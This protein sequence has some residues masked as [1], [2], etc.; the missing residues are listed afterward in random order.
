MCAGL[1]ISSFHGHF[2]IRS[3]DLLALPTVDEDKSFAIQISHE[4][5]LVTQQT[6]Y[7]QCALL[8]T[9]SSGE[10]RI[11]VHTVAAPLVAD[12]GDM[13]KAADGGACVNVLAK[14]G[15]DSD[16]ATQVSRRAAQGAVRF[17]PVIIRA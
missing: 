12:L 4:E 14:L 10:R 8:Y 9:S 15:N 1:K 17:Q 13:Y 2:F 7:F 5:Q 16:P 3:T 6:V 11:R